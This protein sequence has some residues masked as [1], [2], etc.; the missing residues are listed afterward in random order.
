MLSRKV[1]WQAASRSSLTVVLGVPGC[2][3]RG[4]RDPSEQGAQEGRVGRGE[5]ALRVALE[6][7]GDHPLD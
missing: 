3:G 4:C 5:T 6:D 7:L 1:E 2:R